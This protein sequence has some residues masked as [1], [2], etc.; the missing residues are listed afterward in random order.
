MVKYSTAASQVT[1]SIPS[2]NLEIRTAFFTS[3]ASAESLTSPPRL[4]RPLRPGRGHHGCVGPDRVLRHARAPY[5]H[6]TPAAHV[7]YSPLTAE[8]QYCSLTSTCTRGSIRRNLFQATW[9]QL[10]GIFIHNPVRQ[11]LCANSHAHTR[12]SDL[13]AEAQ[14]QLFVSQRDAHI[15]SQK[16]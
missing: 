9:M 15:H 10:T 8:C 5:R 1:T 11:L 13:T 16:R 14:R 4:Q 6:F 3:I 2:P 7:R 12:P